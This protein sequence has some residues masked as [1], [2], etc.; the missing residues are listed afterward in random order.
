MWRGRRRNRTETHPAK[1]FNPADLGWLEVAAVLLV[2]QAGIGLLSTLVQMIM[3][4]IG[5]A[6]SPISLL[7]S[8]GIPAL[9]LASARALLRRRRWA[10]RFALG[11]ESVLILGAGARFVIG[12][13]LAFGLMPLVSLVIL[14]LAVGVVLMRPETRRAMAAAK[15]PRTPLPMP[16]RAW[17]VDHAA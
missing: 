16:P 17:P 7:I 1:A 11:L 8:L 3:A 10:R 5:I 2:V 12:R 6:Q 4:V 9:T 15:R 14:P 13:E